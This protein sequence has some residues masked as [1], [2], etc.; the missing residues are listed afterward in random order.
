MPIKRFKN[1]ETMWNVDFDMEIDRQE[2]EKE[3]EKN[4]YMEQ[5]EKNM[6]Y[7]IT[8][9]PGA[10]GIHSK[11]YD[12][13]SLEEV[14]KLPLIPGGYWLSDI[15][16]ASYAYWCADAY[17]RDD[18]CEWLIDECAVTIDGLLDVKKREHLAKIARKFEEEDN[19]LDYRDRPV[20]LHGT[21]C[22]TDAPNR[23]AAILSGNLELALEFEKCAD[24]RGE[25]EQ[26]HY[27]WY[28]KK[29][30]TVEE[31]VVGRKFS[32][33][34]FTV[35]GVLSGNPKMLEYTIRYE[36][37]EGQYFEDK[38]VWG[39]SAWREALGQAIAGADK[40][41]TLHIIKHHPDMLAATSVEQ[42]V[43]AGN[44]ELLEYM[45]K[46]FETFEWS[47]SYFLHTRTLLTP[48]ASNPGFSRGAQADVGLYRFFLQRADAETYEKILQQMENDI[49][50]VLIDDN[51]YKRTIFGKLPDS[52]ERKHALQELYTELEGKR[53]PSDNTTEGEDLW[54]M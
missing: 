33:P 23:L 14:K 17:G 20:W 18:I 21:K 9:M 25:W 15:P 46:D 5:L 4:R 16:V 12:G 28:H 52:N 47:L 30:H 32:I 29:S 13:I 27:F 6:E 11:I 40:E 26:T 41:M 3:E 43:K 54:W 24:E 7:H 44:V 8:K 39:R 22:R 10:C 2:E 36:K 45:C 50:S 37:E 42:A 53:F 51:Y 38:D 49:E 35:A 19:K 34:D 1:P 31:T 48:L